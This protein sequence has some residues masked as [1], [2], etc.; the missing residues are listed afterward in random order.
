MAST[1]AFEALGEG[2]LAPRA[3]AAAALGPPVDLRAA[4]TLRLMFSSASRRSA[5][6]S[7]CLNVQLYKRVRSE[8]GR[9]AE[10]N[11]TDMFAILIIV[12]VF[13]FVKVVLVKLTNETGK[14][15][16]LEHAREDGLGKLVHILYDKVVALRAPTD[17]MRKGFIF[18]HSNR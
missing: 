17:D 13:D 11:K 9:Q 2:E 12:C 18:E 8:E 10:N 5:W 15:G 1:F 7:G 4:G 6:K 14:V 3:A 16:V